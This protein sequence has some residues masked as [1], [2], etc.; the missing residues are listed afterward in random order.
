MKF[1][2]YMATVV[3]SLPKSMV[4]VALG[5]PSSKNSKAAKWGKVAAI[6][7]VVII[8]IFASMWIRRKMAVATRMSI[9]KCNPP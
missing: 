8:T 7:I 3:L 1:W 5:S 9:P 6:A 4:F 2:I